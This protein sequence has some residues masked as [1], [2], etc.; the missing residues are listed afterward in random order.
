[1][2]NE[3]DDNFIF[4]E[5]RKVLICY[6]LDS[7]SHQS[8][9]MK[10]FEMYAYLFYKIAKH[11]LKLTHKTYCGFIRKVNARER[12]NSKLATQTTPSDRP[13]SAKPKKTK[14]HFCLQTYWSKIIPNIRILTFWHKVLQPYL[15]LDN[16]DF[17]THDRIEDHLQQLNHFIQTQIS[18]RMF[19]LIKEDEDFVKSFT[20]LLNYEKI[21]D[22]EKIRQHPVETIIT[23]YLGILWEK[24]LYPMDQGA[25]FNF[26]NDCIISSDVTESEL[27]QY[28]VI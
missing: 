2:F 18:N 5:N 12:N 10:S 7:Q 27:R 11:V 21:K 6:V 3:K 17:S 4:A 22:G 19:E 16:T 13:A 20:E 14:T 25:E 15:D 26:K 24:S 28:M 23:N 9:V 8:L 1:M